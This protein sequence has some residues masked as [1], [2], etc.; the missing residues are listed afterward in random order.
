M[1]ADDLRTAVINQISKVV[2]S[3]AVIDRHQYPANLRHCI[4]GFELSVSVR[5]DVS[6]AITLPDTEFEQ[7]R[8][9]AITAIQK[10]LVRKP[11]SAIDHRLAIAIELASAASKVQRSKRRFH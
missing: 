11:E 2:G 6:N 10:L 1:R 7:T 8:R 3:Q 4:K 5:R 9:P